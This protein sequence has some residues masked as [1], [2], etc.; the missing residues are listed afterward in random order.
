[1]TE[2]HW[3]KYFSFDIDSVRIVLNIYTEVSQGIT[4]MMQLLDIRIMKDLTYII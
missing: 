1:M 2:G 3:L 4:K